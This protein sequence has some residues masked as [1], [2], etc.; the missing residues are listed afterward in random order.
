MGVSKHRPK[1]K[2]KL[3]ARKKREVARKRQI[4]G[5]VK[6]LE[7]EFARVDSLTNNTTVPTVTTPGVYLT[8]TPDEKEIMQQYDNLEI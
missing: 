5:L 2:Q 1:H 8:P 4:Q 6:D 7:T 3:A